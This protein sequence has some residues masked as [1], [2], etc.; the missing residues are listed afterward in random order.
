MRRGGGEENEGFRGVDA[1]LVILAEAAEVVEPAEGA[2]DDSAPREGDKALLPVG[3]AD[4]F[5]AL[6]AGG[7]A[8]GHPARKF[9]SGV[10]AIGPKE[11]E[12]GKRGVN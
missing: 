8:C 9:V 6:R 11:F 3:A 1:K 5:Q 10:T 12:L 4:D 7:E 2:F